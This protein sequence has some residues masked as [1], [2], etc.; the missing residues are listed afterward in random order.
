M[1]EAATSPVVFWVVIALYLVFLAVAGIRAKG[2][3]ST[4][5]DYMVAGRKIGPILLGLCLYEI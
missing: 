3:T 4:L 1:A 2:K 5:E